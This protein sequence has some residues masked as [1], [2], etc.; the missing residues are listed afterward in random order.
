M[1]I[2]DMEMGLE[3]ASARADAR[4]IETEQRLARPDPRQQPEAEPEALPEP[5]GDL[6]PEGQD[7]LEQPQQVEQA[8]QQAKDQ[9]L[10]EATKAWL[11]GGETPEAIKNAIHEWTDKSTGVL[12]RMTI[13][14]ME[15][16]VLRQSDYQ[17]GMN[18]LRSYHQQVQMREQAANQL[19][20]AF[21]DPEQLFI[22]LQNRDPAV[23]HQ[24]SVKYANKRAQMKQ[25]AEGAGY[26]LMQQ[27]GYQASHPDVVNAVRQSMR[28]QEQ[29]EK[30]EVENRKLLQHNQMF[31]QMQQQQV[32]QQRQQVRLQDLSSAI[33]PLIGPS[34]QKVGVRNSPTN[35]EA[36]YRHLHAYTSNLPNWDG[37]VRRSHCIEA[38]K[39]VREELEDLA[40]ARAPKR[41]APQSRAMG[42][43][44][45][46]SGGSAQP[47]TPEKKRISDMANDPR[48]RFGVG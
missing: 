15:E 22:E 5:E 40:A 27:Y 48:F 32:N 7:D 46:T 37:N 13:S 33:K 6:L 34:F 9:E 42:P 14:Q 23:F 36:F 44:K 41:P 16:G 10:L 38:A 25:I 45:L 4:A 19:E 35:E 20:Q 28:A 43:S 39:M 26:A 1:R 24:V 12:R 29:A 3:Q 31:A 21:R 11:E 18:E 47:T 2:S 30:V 8:A 17:R